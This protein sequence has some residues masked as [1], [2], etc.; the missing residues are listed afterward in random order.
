MPWVAL[1]SFWKKQTPPIS[2]ENG[3]FPPPKEEGK[4]KKVMYFTWKNHLKEPF[5]WSGFR[6]PLLC[7]IL[8]RCLVLSYALK[9]G[10]KLVWNLIKKRQQFQTTGVSERSWQGIKIDIYWGLWDVNREFTL[11]FTTIA[12]EQVCHCSCGIS[13]SK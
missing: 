1:A 5:T 9:P 4:K 7:A 12:I 6:K 8:Y 13:I 11:L 2:K 10:I 3:S